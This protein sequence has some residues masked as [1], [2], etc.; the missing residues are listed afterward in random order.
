MREILLICFGCLTSFGVGS[1][2]GYTM[3][4]R[5]N[6]IET[7]RDVERINE[8]NEAARLS[9]LPNA[10]ANLRQQSDDPDE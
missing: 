10:P 9:R 2:I 3:A 4:V 7:A 5:Q 1:C 6:V 8:I